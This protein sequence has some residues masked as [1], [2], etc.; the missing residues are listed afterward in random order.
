MRQNWD[1]WGHIHLFLARQLLPSSQLISPYRFEVLKFSFLFPFTSFRWIEESFGAAIN[2][3]IGVDWIGRDDFRSKEGNKVPWWFWGGCTSCFWY[4]RRVEKV[5]LKGHNMLGGSIWVDC[6]DPI[7]TNITRLFIQKN[8]IVWQSHSFVLISKN[9]VVEQ[10]TMML[11]N[12][13][14][15]IGPIESQYL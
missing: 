4:M 11:A 14:W 6:F 10:L 15:S 2:R 12:M 13:N 8:E 3:S 1:S 9:V 5:L 7:V